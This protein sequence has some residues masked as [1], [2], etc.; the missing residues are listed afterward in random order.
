MKGKTVYHLLALFVT[1]VWGATFVSTKV[2]LLYGLTPANIF[3]IRFLMAYIIVWFVGPKTIWAAAKKDELLFVVLGIT[4]GSLY[5]LAE[6]SALK[7]TLASNV[8]LIICTA[9]LLTAFLSHFFVKGERLSKSLIYGS[10]L[11][12]AGVAFVVYNGSFILKVNPIGDLLTVSAALLWGFYTIIYKHLDA[13]Y[14]VLFITRKVFFYGLITITPTFF[15]SPFLTGAAILFH[16]VVAANLLFLG[17]IA[18]M[19]CYF[20]WNIAIK[21]L[22][23]IKTTNYIYLTPIVTLITS[24]IVLKETITPVALLG[25]ALILTGVS[26]AERGRS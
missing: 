19:L 22:G 8:S 2:L 12:L 24:V 10:V 6:N 4:G 11:A 26:L 20:L 16:P 9:P 5:F 23:A 7:Y 17:L 1:I 13:R 21:H 14:P 25:A 18:S 3:F 15:F